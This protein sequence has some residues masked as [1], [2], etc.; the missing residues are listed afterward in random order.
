MCACSDSSVKGSCPPEARLSWT[1]LNLPVARGILAI[2]HVFDVRMLVDF[3]TGI[4][5]MARFNPLPILGKTTPI[6]RLFVVNGV[7][8]GVSDRM[9]SRPLS[10][11][12]NSTRTCGT[13]LRTHDALRLSHA[14]PLSCRP[15]CL[16][17]ASTASPGA[18]SHTVRFVF[19]FS[20]RWTR[21]ELLFLALWRA[22]RPRT[23]ASCR[24]PLRARATKHF[25][26]RRTSPTR[27][28]F[29][30]VRKEPNPGSTGNA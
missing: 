25:V 2:R 8:F 26:P 24:R 17:S 12:A 7:V 15:R 28:G 27:P 3:T 22:N 9:E 6:R 16:L 4:I 20:I 30:R 5:L 1:S 14:D 21:L 10:Q 19:R 11:A 13:K 23:R 18:F 29:F